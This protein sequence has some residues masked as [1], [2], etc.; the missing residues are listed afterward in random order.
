MSPKFLLFIIRRPLPQIV[1][2]NQLEYE[3][4]IFPISAHLKLYAINKRV[5]LSRN[6]VVFLV[7]QYSLFEWKIRL[8]LR[9]IIIENPPSVQSCFIHMI[10]HPSYK[11]LGSELMLLTR[12]HRIILNQQIVIGVNIV[13]TRFFTG[14]VGFFLEWMGGWCWG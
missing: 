2:K 11:M 12:Q 9:T 5:L 13:C 7:W 1:N 4:Q 8:H 6:M 14:C 3:E 10:K